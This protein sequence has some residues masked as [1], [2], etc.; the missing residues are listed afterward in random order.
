MVTMC[1]Q[2][3]TPFPTLKGCEWGYLVFQRKRLEPRLLPWQ[4]HKG[5]ILFLL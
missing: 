3:K 2:S 5:V 4:Q 1:I